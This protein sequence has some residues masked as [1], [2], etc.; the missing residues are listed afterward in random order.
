MLTMCPAVGIKIVVASLAEIC[1]LALVPVI[2]K[3]PVASVN[4]LKRPYPTVYELRFGQSC[5]DSD[6]PLAAVASFSFAG[7][8]GP[9]E[10]HPKALAE[11][12]VN[13]SAH[14]APIIQP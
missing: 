5:W 6:N 14:T 12:Y 13:V 9:G 1:W 2:V 11:P 7:V 4:K 10:F 8:S 3:V